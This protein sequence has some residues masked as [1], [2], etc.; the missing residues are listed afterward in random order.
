[1]F[2]LDGK[3]AWVT[4]SAQN[5]GKAMLGA[6]AEQGA[7][8]VV[9][10]RSNDERLEETVREFRSEYETEVLGVQLDIADQESV[11]AAYD[12]I[13]DELGPVDVLVNNAAI[14]PH[15]ELDE[16]TLDIWERVV[17]TNLTGS[18]VVTNAVLPDM[19]RRGWGRVINVTGDGIW[20]GPRN[21]L[22]IVSSKA[23]LVGFT[24]V[25]ANEVADDGVTVNCMSPGLFDT[26]R[27]PEWYDTGEGMELAYDHAEERIPL[28]RVGRPEDIAPA[29]VFFASEESRWITGQVLHVNGGFYPITRNPYT[30]PE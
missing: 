30:E 15:R 10:N 24:R 7:R 8:V 29:A 22:P 4:G 17:R 25:L 21:T 18:Y 2:D 28:G 27:H 3:T 13:T 1:M 16:L 6:M 12:R 9:S 5:L 19:Q 20:L 23:G 14:R 26:E 11:A